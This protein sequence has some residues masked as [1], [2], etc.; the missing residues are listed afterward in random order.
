MKPFSLSKILPLAAFVVLSLPPQRSAANETS[1]NKGAFGTFSVGADAVG[2]GALGSYEDYWSPSAGARLEFGTPFYAGVLR[3]GGHLF[4]NEASAADVP[5]FLG[6]WGYLGWSYEWLLPKRFAVSAGVETGVMYMV[7]DD[8]TI[9][10]A[11]RNE[12]ELGFG[13][14]SRLRYAFAGS[15]SVVVSGEY[16]VVLTEREIEYLFGG[17]GIVRTFASPKWL[18]EFLE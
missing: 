16:R 13:V 11:R 7:F 10:E 2:G 17:V 15:W 8:D 1:E 5:S 12:T 18:R 14:D 6:L 9:H 4:D 3:A